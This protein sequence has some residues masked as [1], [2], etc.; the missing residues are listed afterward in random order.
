MVIEVTGNGLPSR[1]R[2]SIYLFPREIWREKWK[3]KEFQNNHSKGRYPPVGKFLPEE[4]KRE[5]VIAKIYKFDFSIRKKIAGENASRKL[6]RRSELG[7]RDRIVIITRRKR[8]VTTSLLPSS[9]F[10]ILNVT[11]AVV[12]SMRALTH[13]SSSSSSPTPRF[14]RFYT[15]CMS[16]SPHSFSPFSFLSRFNIFWTFHIIIFH[17]LHRFVRL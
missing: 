17:P 13:P 11:A 5:S 14:P 4:K 9:S 15:S 8:Q 16:Q 12:E 10:V 1:R 2:N 7:D 3:I 6:K